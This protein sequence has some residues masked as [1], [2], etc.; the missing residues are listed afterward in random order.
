MCDEEEMGEWLCVLC[1][2]MKPL[3][4]L[5]ATVSSTGR[6]PFGS[7][8][9]IV[10]LTSATKL[11]TVFNFILGEYINT[12]FIRSH[13]GMACVYTARVNLMVKDRINKIK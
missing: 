5:A 2:K 1:I 4:I 9:D 11:H 7:A 10:R 13:Q 8:S 3:V 6:R 12:V